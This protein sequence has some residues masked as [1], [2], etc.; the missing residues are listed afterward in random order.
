MHPHQRRSIRLVNADYSV[1]GWF[2]VTICTAKHENIF[3]EVVGGQMVLNEYGMMAKKCWVDIPQHY[4]NVIIDE[5]IIMPNH[6]H[7]VIK[8]FKNNILSQNNTSQI[9]G[10]QNIEPLRH[11]SQ[12]IN[13]HKYQHTISGSLGAIVRGYKIGVTK[14]FKQSGYQDSPWQRNFYE[15]IIHSPKE[16]NNIRKYIRDNP[17][18]WDTDENNLVNY[19]KTHKQQS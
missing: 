6:V 4:Q 16:L 19:L 2:F 17:V 1:P 7:G 14:L 5:F 11:P 12:Q 9:V 13:L 15:H 3:G 18:K 8:I 10:V